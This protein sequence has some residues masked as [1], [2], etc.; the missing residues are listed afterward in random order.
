MEEIPYVVHVQESKSTENTDMHV[1]IQERKKK[2]HEAVICCN[3]FQSQSSRALINL[4]C[5]TG[6]RVP[7]A[8]HLCNTAQDCTRN[9]KV[10]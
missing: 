4:L 3:P 9:Q 2:L 5:L 10:R 6:D 8:Y 1:Y 7:C